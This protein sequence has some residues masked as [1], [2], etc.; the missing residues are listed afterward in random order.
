MVGRFRAEFLAEKVLLKSVDGDGRVVSVLRILQPRSIVSKTGWDIFGAANEQ[1]FLRLKLPSQIVVTWHVQDGLHAAGMLRRQQSRHE[2]FYDLAESSGA[3]QESS[4]MQRGKD[5]VAGLR[6]VLH[7]ASSSIKWGLSPVITEQ[8]LDDL[9]LSIKSC[10]NSSNALHRC[11][12]AFVLRFARYRRTAPDRDGRALWWT[13]LGVPAPL[14][15]WVLRVNP[16]WDPSVVV[17]WVSGELEGAV[18]G[19]DLIEN[20]V[21]FFL[22]WR[23]FSGTRWAG[24]GPSARHLICSLVVGVEPLIRLVDAEGH[25]NDR[26]HLSAAKARTLPLVKKLAAVAAL[27]AF[28]VESMSLGLL[29]D[30]RFLLVAESLWAEAQSQAEWV[31]SLPGSIYDSLSALVGDPLWPGTTARSDVLLSARTSMSYMRREAYAQLDEFPLLATQGDIRGKVDEI[32]ALQSPPPCLMGQK[33]H[34]CCRFFRDEAIE[35]LEL[36]RQDRR[37]HPQSPPWRRQRSPH[38]SGLSERDED[39]VPAGASIQHRAIES[40]VPA[41]LAQRSKSPLLRPECVLQ[42]GHVCCHSN[43]VG[44]RRWQRAGYHEGVHFL[45]Q[46]ALRRAVCRLESRM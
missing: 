35:A 10:N 3:S 17:S 27:S 23:N 16:S 20:V 21:T 8:L 18:D 25:G 26:Y 13:C 40:E 7:C 42:L 37:I 22:R 44:V 33:L 5:W 19:S 39:S 14:L 41:E 11:V 29:E 43:S 31:G 12:P 9:H 24:V 45:A 1:P 32:A 30:D 46:Q 2:L 4:K 6:C 15:D 34:F 36:L 28:P 38:D